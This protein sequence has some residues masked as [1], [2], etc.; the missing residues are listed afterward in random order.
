M[1]VRDSLVKLKEISTEGI[2]QDVSLKN[3]HSHRK[4]AAAAEKVLISSDIY[5]LYICIFTTRTYVL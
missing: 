1:N 2:Y 4:M 3:W 5:R